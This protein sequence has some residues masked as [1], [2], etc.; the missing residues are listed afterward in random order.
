M[1]VLSFSIV[2]L[3]TNLL[4]KKDKLDENHYTE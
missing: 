4:E 1:L 2:D 3:I